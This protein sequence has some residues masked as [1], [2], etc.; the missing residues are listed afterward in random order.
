MP[1]EETKAAVRRFFQDVWNDAKVAEA[2]SF[3]AQ[4]FVSHNSF[5][6][7]VTGPE[8]Y[9]R[10]VLAYRL[11]FPDLVTTVEDALAE[12][13]RVAVRGT[14]RGTHLGTFMGYPPTG[15]FVTTTWIEIFRLEGGKAVEG[16][17]ET[18]VKRLL[19][20]LVENPAD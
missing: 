4:E 15:Q 5:G 9:G 3:L 17:V 13:D 12:G 14:D 18:D 10:A 6:I 1:E 2:A 16:W 8:E 20:Q 19:D 7:S 11:A